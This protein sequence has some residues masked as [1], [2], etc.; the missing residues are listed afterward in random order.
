MYSQ[1]ADYALRAVLLLARSGNDRPM[2]AD[3]IARE[4]DAPKNYMAKT[5]NALAKAGIVS[6][7]RG[8]QGGF[9]LALPAH[10]LTLARVIDCFDEPR[11]RHRCMLGSRPCDA[12]QPCAAH[13]R[14]TRLQAQRREPLATTTISDLIS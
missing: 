3:V 14:W 10:E 12:E 5:L 8:P 6:S 4:I 11:R 7:A 13:D 9:A 2:H 1:T